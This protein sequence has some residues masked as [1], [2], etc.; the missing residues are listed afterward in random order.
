[1]G[2]VGTSGESFR[3]S[4]KPGQSQFARWINTNPVQSPPGN[5]NLFGIAVKPDGK[6]FY[7][8]QDDVNNLMEAAP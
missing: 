4:T 8:V 1:L 5:G 6:G 3:V 2:I 7:Y